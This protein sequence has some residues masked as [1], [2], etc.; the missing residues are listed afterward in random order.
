MTT[1]SAAPL[2]DDDMEIMRILHDAFRR[3]GARLARAAERYGSADPETHDALLLG[4][5]GFS[6]GL[7]HH[8]T[9]EDTHIW[10]L[11]RDKLTDRPDDLAVLDA[12]EEEHARIDPTL[13][14]LEEAFDDPGSTPDAVAERIS[15]VVELLRSHLAHEERAAFPLIRQ[16]ITTREW[17]VLNK[18][19]MKE[20]SYSEIAALGP[21]LLDGASP[22]DVRRVLSELPAP[23][24]LVHRFWWNPRYQRIRRWE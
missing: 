13:A 6:S 12:M 16:H 17:A 9:I 1:T 11:L 8:H 5:H 21:Y 19:A 10:P 20:L 4:W 14:G 7:H 3:D 22:D 2:T 23:L 15:D 24:R 18:S